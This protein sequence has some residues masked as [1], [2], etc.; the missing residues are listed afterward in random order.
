MRHHD[1]HAE[2]KRERVEIDGAIS[3][4]RRDCADRHHQRGARE[5]DPGA[6]E[7]EPGNTPERDAAISEKEDDRGSNR[8]RNCHFEACREFPLLT[9]VAAPGSTPGRQVSG[10]VI[11]NKARPAPA[12]AANVRNA[13][14]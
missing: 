9:I 11:Q 14:L 13:A 12:I 1:H 2:Q 3:F 8:C 7:P 4:V 10:T 6:I 5:R